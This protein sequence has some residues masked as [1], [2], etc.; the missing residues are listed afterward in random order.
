MFYYSE[1]KTV[2]NG[3]P[4]TTTTYKTGDRNAIERQFH[5][6]CASAVANESGADMDV[7]EWGTLENGIIERK[8]YR[9]PA[10]TPEPEPEPEPE[11]VEDEQAS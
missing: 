9:K 6:F 10:P 8:V 7:C 5:L 1:R 4:K 2:E 3:A 11:P